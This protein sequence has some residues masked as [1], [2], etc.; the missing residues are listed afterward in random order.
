MISYFVVTPRGTIERTGTIQEEHLEGVVA[1]PGETLCVGVANSWFNYYKDGMLHEYTPDQ[2]HMRAVSK[3]EGFEWDAI[4][5]SWV[6]VRSITQLQIGK[7]Y[8]AQAERDRRASL[9]LTVSGITVSADDGAVKRAI[10]M[11]ALGLNASA[12][13]LKWQ[14][15]GGV[16]RTFPTPVGFRSFCVAVNQAI[17]EQVA[18]ADNWLWD[19]QSQIRAAKTADAVNAIVW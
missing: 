3:P 14:D 10:L 12:A 1:G 4:L 16:V 2:L 9:P 5:M 7:M 17:A 13:L 6:D 18:A 15:L 8:M 11:Q 19:M